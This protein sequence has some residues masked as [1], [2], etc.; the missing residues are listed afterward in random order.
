MQASYEELDCRIIVRS[1]L[2]RTAWEKLCMAVVGNPVHMDVVLAEPHS[3]SARFCFSSYVNQE[4]E[5]CLMDA[6]QVMDSAFINQSICITKK[7]YDSCMKFMMGLV[8]S[9]AKYDYTDALLLMPMAPKGMRSAARFASLFKDIL[10]DVEVDAENKM[11]EGSKKKVFCSQSV[12]LMLR[13]C[14]DPEGIHGPL[15]EKLAL[16]NSRLVS[17]KM[18]FGCIQDHPFCEAMSNRELQRLGM[19]CCPSD[20]AR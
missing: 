19:G 12:A 8:E 3:S 14:L 5:M 2:A 13:E 9:R 10:Q 6:S 4:F 16:L 1:R 11:L 17:P 20:G 18:V 15:V 7:E